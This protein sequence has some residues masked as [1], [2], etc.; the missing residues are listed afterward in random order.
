[1]RPTL[2]T[3]TILLLLTGCGRTPINKKLFHF[4]EPLRPADVE[5]F[6]DIAKSLPESK[7]LA[8]IYPFQPPAKWDEDRT[9]PVRDLVSGDLQSLDERWQECA[10]GER[11]AQSKAVE[12]VLKRKHV[13]RERF[14]S[15]AFAIG[16]ACSLNSVPDDF[17]INWH[18]K[19]A[20]SVVLD[21]RKDG[22]VFNSL[23]PEIGH[24][25]LGRA[26]WITEYH[27]GERLS[28]VPP[29][30]A[31]LMKHYRDKL[32]DVLPSEFFGCPYNVMLD[33]NASRALPFEDLPGN[34]GLEVLTW[35][36]T[37]AFKGSDDVDA[38]RRD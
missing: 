28:H 12:R 21:L 36:R 18:L 34:E 2:W 6:L 16:V 20:Q 32:K 15:L 14:A 31:Q 9:L 27:R 35:D 22:R 11:P 19:R 24:E 25:V 3:I 8:T 10:L 7:L 26:A 13:T 1:M 23:A 4:D 30:N 17:D 38:R 5:L 29:Y 37:S 33:R